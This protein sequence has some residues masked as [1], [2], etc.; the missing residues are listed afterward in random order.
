VNKDR[1]IATTKQRL[2]N[3]LRARPPGIHRG[4][5]HAVTGDTATIHAALAELLRE[6]VVEERVYRH[7]RGKPRRE[8]ILAEYAARYAPWPEENEEEQGQELLPGAQM[9]VE[10]IVR[11]CPGTSRSDM[12]TKAVVSKN[13]VARALDKLCAEGRIREEMVEDP[14]GGLRRVYFPAD[15]YKD[16]AYTAD[17]VRAS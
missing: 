2:I 14:R 15:F 16:N 3:L 10:H 5:L 17:V 13:W 11:T 7:V 6:G 4:G 8:Y 12:W 1:S 9:I